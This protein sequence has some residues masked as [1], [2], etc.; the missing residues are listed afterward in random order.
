[1]A[2]LR[3]R[4]LPSGEIRWLVDYR[5]SVG[6]RRAKQFETKRDA[7][8]YME[9]VRAEVAAGIHVADSQSVTLGEAADVWVEAGE[10]DR[11]ETTTVR[12][13]RQHVDL[14]IKPLI[15]STR[16]SRLNTP[17]VQEF[18]DKLLET[19]SRAMARRVLTSLRGILAETQRR[20][21][22]AHNPA[23]VAKV[24][25]RRD[26]GG[27]AETVQLPPKA[28]LRL[29]LAKAAELWP[30]VRRNGR[31]EVITCCWRP[32]VVTAIL[33]GMRASELRGLAWNPRGR[34]GRVA[35]YGDLV[36]WRL[37]SGLRRPGLSA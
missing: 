20:G 37:G 35:V 30:T 29:M 10:R 24:A 25:K 5:D 18:V 9:K 26:E 33:T 11:L 36:G 7:D 31:G 32:L 1:M 23:M 15:G 17:I 14:H 34:V 2:S 3:K 22:I 13:R 16:L 21:L 6:T 12:Q 8:A 28:H 19:R 27:D 4:I